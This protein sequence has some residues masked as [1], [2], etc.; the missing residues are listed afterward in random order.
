[1]LKFIAG[2]LVII[3]SAQSFALAA[4]SGAPEAPQDTNSTLSNEFSRRQVS[5]DEARKAQYQAIIVRGIYQAAED[6]SGSQVNSQ[7]EIKM[8]QAGA[9]F[10]YFHMNNGQICSV[11]VHYYEGKLITVFSSGTN[12]H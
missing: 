3:A 12:C 7:P 8:N 6:S 1:M 5:E 2:F 11:P 10:W 9:T 4:N